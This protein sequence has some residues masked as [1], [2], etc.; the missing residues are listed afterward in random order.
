MTLD[1]TVSHDISCL[2]AAKDFSQYLILK[3]PEAPKGAAAMEKIQEI[4]A[5]ESKVVLDTYLAAV[6][7]LDQESGSEDETFLESIPDTY[8]IIK[9]KVEEAYQAL[10]SSGSADDSDK[11]IYQQFLINFKEKDVPMILYGC[12][13][14]D[15]QVDTF[16]LSAQVREEAAYA[17]YLASADINTAEGHAAWQIAYYGGLYLRNATRDDKEGKIAVSQTDL[18]RHLDIAVAD[19]LQCVRESALIENSA[20]LQTK[21]KEWLF[22]EINDRLSR[23]LEFNLLDSVSVRKGEDGLIYLKD[24]EREPYTVE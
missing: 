6:G 23:G 17:K 19:G 13:G 12:S 8:Q 22:T 3:Q 5:T 10:L 9:S 18:E 20:E 15:S 2:Y 4:L 21:A 24:D 16:T 11:E 14:K 7:D 1:E